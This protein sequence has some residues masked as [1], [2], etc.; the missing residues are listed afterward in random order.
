MHSPGL[1]SLSPIANDSLD[2]KNLMATLLRSERQTPKVLNKITLLTTG[3]RQAHAGVV[4]IN[5]LCKRPEST[6]VIKPALS[7]R[8]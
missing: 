7:M 6:V 5:D 8:K 3:K 4:V 1:Q 2:S